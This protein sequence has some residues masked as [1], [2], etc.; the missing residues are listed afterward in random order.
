[1]SAIE[2]TSNS[3]PTLPVSTAFSD[4]YILTQVGPSTLVF[5]AAW[6][7]EIVRAE[8][9]QVLELPFYDPLILGIV[10]H[11]GSV[12]P[13]IASH[14][15]LQLEPP[16]LREM[17]TIVRLSE[18][19]GSLVN[20]GLIVDRAL[21][22]T[23]RSQLPSTLFEASATSPLVNTPEAAMVLLNQAWFDPQMWQPQRWRKSAA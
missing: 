21:G 12:V 1:M 16:I 10:H 5:P 11:N 19:A 13:L 8:R 3:S 22:S 20:L 17:L 4:R 15:V 7:F 18:A 14:R 2:I 9:S 6:V 23:T